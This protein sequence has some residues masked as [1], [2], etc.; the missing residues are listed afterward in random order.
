MGMSP[1]SLKRKLKAMTG[2]TPQPFIQ[3]MRLKRAAS[4]IATGNVTVSE[5][6]ARVGIYNMSYF[7]KIFRSEYG[8]A[9][10]KYV[11]KN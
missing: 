8:I 11:G 4:L 6:A 5:A 7:S 2:L 9:P 3:K 1:S 10:S